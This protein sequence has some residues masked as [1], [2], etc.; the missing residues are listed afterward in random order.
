MYM[1]CVL[2]TVLVT[3]KLPL[4]K[5]KLLPH[6]DGSNMNN[7]SLNVSAV[8]VLERRNGCNAAAAFAE[9]RPKL[10]VGASV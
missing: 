8:N 7:I 4:D 3:T 2:L 1:L 9:M 5:T 10:T 6:D